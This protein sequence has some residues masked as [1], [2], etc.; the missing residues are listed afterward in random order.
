MCF[1]PQWSECIWRGNDEI[2]RLLFWLV[3]VVLQNDIPVFSPALTDGAIGDFLYLF[4]VESPGLILDIT[5]GTSLFFF[6]CTGTIVCKCTFSWSNE[7]CLTSDISRMNSM[8]VAANS[9]G[10]IVLGGGVAKHHICNANVWVSIDEQFWSLQ[11]S[12]DSL[13][14]LKLVKNKEKRVLVLKYCMSC[15]VLHFLWLI[16]I[17]KYLEI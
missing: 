4:S 15:R 16:D 1:Q 2:V 12:L 14:Y 8:A 11:K 5:E 10:I 9:T 3:G 13:T 17:L 7:T 6:F